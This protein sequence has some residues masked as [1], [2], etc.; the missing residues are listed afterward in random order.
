MTA[1]P[2]IKYE[3]LVTT[4]D[5]AAIPGVHEVTG[6]VLALAYDEQWLA[7]VAGDD[8][9]LYSLPLVRCVQ[10]GEGS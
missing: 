8:G 3:G 1:Y 6:T 5:G 10:I 4:L 7:A 9:R 2:R